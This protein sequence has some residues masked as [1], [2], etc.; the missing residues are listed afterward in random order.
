MAAALGV[1]DAAAGA[2]F[3]SAERSCSR[4]LAGFRRWLRAHNAPVSGYAGVIRLGIN[5]VL[6]AGQFWPGLVAAAVF[7]PFPP[8]R[9]A[10]AR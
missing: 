5:A 3:F 7:L 8:T 9:F 1:V 4:R 6:A 10:S 2:R